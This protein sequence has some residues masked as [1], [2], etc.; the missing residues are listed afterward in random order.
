MKKI[1]FKDLPSTDTPLNSTNLNQM[2]DNMENAIIPIKLVSISDTAPVSATIGDMYY[3]T[4]DNK[5]YTA[6]G[7]NTWDSGS[8]PRYDGFYVNTSNNTLFY[9][10]GTSLVGVGGS[11]TGINVKNVETDSTTDAY[12][13]NYINNINRKVSYKSVTNT[14]RITFTP[15]YDCYVDITL[16]DN[17]WGYDA[18]EVT[19]SIKNTTGNATEIFNYSSTG[20][21]G[22]AVARSLVARAVYECSQGQTYTFSRSIQNAGG[23]KGSY[24][25]AQ[26]FPK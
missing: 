9:Y 24:M 18:G 21:E 25:V 6:T 2:Q 15:E 8:T 1:P 5:V 19:L 26:I 22:N 7:T 4:T 11:Q 12:S 3:N 23:S 14:N 20:N 17:T 10:N 16:V 13:C